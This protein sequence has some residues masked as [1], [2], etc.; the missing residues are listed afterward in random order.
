[1]PETTRRRIPA[2]N[3]ST[4]FFDRPASQCWLCAHADASDDPKPTCKAFPGGIPPEIRRNEVDHRA[5]LDGDDGT[6]FE[7]DGDADGRALKRLY[8]H[9]DSLDDTAEPEPEPEGP[10]DDDDE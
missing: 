9:L 10:E 8:Q 4:S 6:T 3:I 2:E 7:P 5:S 1:M